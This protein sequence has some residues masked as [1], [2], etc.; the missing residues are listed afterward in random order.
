MA[1]PVE[2]PVQRLDVRGYRCPLPVVRM[3]AALRKMEP[4]DRLEVIADD[5][6]AAI[7]IPHAC[8][9]GGHDV[10]REPDQADACVFLVTC[11]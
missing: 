6:I 5:P 10:V 8:R 7:D 9:E 4:G 3:E 11:G 1:K 2:D